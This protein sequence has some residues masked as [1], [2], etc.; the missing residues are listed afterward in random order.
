M[1]EKLNLLKANE[2]Y[3]TAARSPEILNVTSAKFLSI[4]GHGSPSETIFGKKIDLLFLVAHKLADQFNSTDKAF[5]VSV[6][7]GLYWHA[8]KFGFINISEIFSKVSES[9]LEYRLLIRIPDYVTK[10]DV[11]KAIKTAAAAENKMAD[12]VELVERSEGKCV[13]ILHLGAFENEGDN[14]TKMEDY[15]KPLKLIKAGQHHEIYLVNFTKEKDSSK[16]VTIL[17]EQVK[18]K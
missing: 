9:E 2:S 7:E 16:Y 6:L 5:E 13:Q 17:R 3:Y 10:E 8:E 1:M 12:E 18:D 15:I 11:I 4:L 14:L